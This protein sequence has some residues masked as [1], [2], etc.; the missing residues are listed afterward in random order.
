MID[1]LGDDFID[2]TVLEIGTH[3]GYT[4]RIL[5]FLF[6][7]VITVDNSPGFISRARNLN[8]DRNKIEY[9]E[10]DIYDLGA[11]DDFTEKVDAVFIDA[12]HKYRYVLMD[13]INSL[14]TFKDIYLIYDDYGMIPQ[15]KRAIDDCLELGII[16][17]VDHIGHE[18]GLDIK[19]DGTNQILQ[20]REG[21][22]CK[23]RS[24]K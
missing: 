10:G 22:I 4:A 11:F 20:G 6:K 14:K 23:S 13:T 12:V 18:K 17:F 2:K 7:R 16:K 19:Q 8:N 5:S 15:V 24:K 21:I 9:F 1:F 3:Y